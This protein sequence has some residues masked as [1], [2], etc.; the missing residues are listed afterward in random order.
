MQFSIYNKYS[1]AVTSR[2]G[3]GEKSSYIVGVTSNF[4]VYCF[5]VVNSFGQ[6]RE[7]FGIQEVNGVHSGK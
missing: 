1:A 6:K 4:N 2:H 5:A 3:I 7:I